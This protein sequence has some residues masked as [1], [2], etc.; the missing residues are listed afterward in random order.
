[1]RTARPET[2]V[3]EDN[4]VVSASRKCRVLRCISSLRDTNVLGELTHRLLVICSSSLTFRCCC[5][6]AADMQH[7][8]PI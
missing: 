3:R 2:E 1:M 5:L 7:A 8:N 6:L 4:H